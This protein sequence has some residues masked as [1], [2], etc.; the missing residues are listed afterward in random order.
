MKLSNKYLIDF[1]T[2]NKIIKHWNKDKEFRVINIIKS[3][4]ILKE[5]LLNNNELI[6]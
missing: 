1:E 6:T 5:Y 2:V 3:E 4:D